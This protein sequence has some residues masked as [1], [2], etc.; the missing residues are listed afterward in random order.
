VTKSV[1]RGFSF[2]KMDAIRSH[3]LKSK[4]SIY[5]VFLISLSLFPLNYS[6]G[7][8]IKIR[9]LFVGNSLTSAN[10]LPNTI[11]QL[12]KSRDFIM[13]YQMYAPGGYGLSQHASD[14]ALAEKIGQGKWDFVVL[15]EQSQ[16]PSFSQEQVAREVYPFARKL[17]QMIRQA[18]PEAKIVFYLTMAKKN[19]D[20]QNAK[21]FPELAT[22]S[23]MQDNLNSSYFHMA[24]QNQ[25]LLAPV[26]I[27]WQ[28]VRSERPR[29]ELYNDDTH[30]NTTGSYLAA[31]VFYSL[32]FN[33]S[34]KGLPHPREIRN[35][36]A[37]Y[38]QGMAERTVRSQ[39][40]D[41]Q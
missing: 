13:E 4:L 17:C 24:R 8:P 25:S 19:G 41:R 31:C 21:A 28:S 35:D 22:Y 33:D 27:A 29:I 16:R 38:L 30:P 20:S 32:L 34:P 11:A 5:I 23:G 36:I 3:L 39:P 12:A 2:G 15:Q 37:L 18:N 14:P 9:V 26:G 1:A 6:L 10:D 40:W 7:G